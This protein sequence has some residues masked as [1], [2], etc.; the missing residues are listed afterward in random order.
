MAYHLEM[1]ITDVF[2]FASFDYRVH[3]ASQINWC[4]KQFMQNGRTLLQD[5]LWPGK[6]MASLERKH[7]IKDHQT[8]FAVFCDMR[9]VAVTVT[10]CIAPN[11]SLLLV[12]PTEYRNVT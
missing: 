1:M 11:I 9:Y 8:E 7:Q 5:S 2:S 6:S 3:M 12:T 10:E 4:P